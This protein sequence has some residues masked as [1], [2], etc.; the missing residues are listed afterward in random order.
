MKVACEGDL[1]DA[2]YVMGILHELRPY[3]HTLILRSSQVTAMK[4]GSSFEK[5][6]EM[7]K[8]LADL[9]EYIEE[10]KPLQPSDQIEWDSGGFRGAGLHEVTNTLLAAHVSHLRMT[11]GIGG[12]I[13]GRLKWLDA[14]PSPRSK[15]RVIIS[16]TSRYQNPL[17]PWS[18]VVQFYGDRILFMGLP[19]EH[20]GFCDNFGSVE[21]IGIRNLLDAAELISGSLLFMGNQS[22]FNAIAEGLKHTIIQETSLSIPDCIYKRNN[23]RHVTNGSMTLPGFGGPDLYI[24]P[25]PVPRGNVTTDIA[26]PGG[27][28]HPAL[29]DHNGRL[30]HFWGY[31]QCYKELRKIEPWNQKSKD[32]IK[33]AVLDYIFGEHPEWQNPYANSYLLVHQAKV[34]AGILV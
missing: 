23:A 21:H 18:K 15:D 8:P 16:R 27:W 20:Q 22:S 34:N 12:G 10:C 11:R 17:F 4:P 2:V 14:K 13:N 24:P 5:F 30:R 29:E 19:H 28:R 25:Q 32:E 9:Q 1:G 31:D 6:V 33:N 7:V 3:P 26:P